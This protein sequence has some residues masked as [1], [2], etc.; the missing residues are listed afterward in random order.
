[1]MAINFPASPTDGQTF[2]VGNAIYTYSTATGTWSAAPLGTALPFNLLI[3]PGM[4]VSQQN[5]R[6]AC[7]IVGNGAAAA[8]Y[9]ADQWAVTWS[10][11]ST[12]TT[13]AAGSF[14]PGTFNLGKIAAAKIDLASLM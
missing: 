1:M 4:L 9:V 3:N 6:T 11:V 8:Y 2:V 7:S 12:K 14:D 10:I 13:M 5:G